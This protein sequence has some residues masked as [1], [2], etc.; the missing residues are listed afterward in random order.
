MGKAVE[1]A[2]S[3]LC[4]VFAPDSRTCPSPPI[5]YSP[6]RVQLSYFHHC[7]SSSIFQTGS[8]LLL[9]TSQQ[10]LHTPSG[11]P[12]PLSKGPKPRHT[13]SEVLSLSCGQ[14]RVPK[15]TRGTQ[16]GTALVAQVSTFLMNQYAYYVSGL[17]S[18]LLFYQEI[19]KEHEKGP[20]QVC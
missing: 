8:L 5:L 12:R 14:P 7:S 13:Q 15:D 9:P 17:T 18:R 4:M 19:S 2:G 11:E 20:Y 6:P 10:L 16:S 3:A 1:A